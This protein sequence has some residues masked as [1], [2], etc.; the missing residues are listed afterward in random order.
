[1]RTR[2]IASVGHVAIK[3]SLLLLLLATW[4]CLAWKKRKIHFERL[5]EFGV[6]GWDPVL[7]IALLVARER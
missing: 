7:T 6:G 3:A 1:M 5:S 4:S 2:S